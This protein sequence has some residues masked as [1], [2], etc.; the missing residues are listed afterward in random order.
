MQAPLNSKYDD[1][2]NYVHHISQPL[3]SGAQ[4]VA[5]GVLPNLNMIGVI[6]LWRRRWRRWERG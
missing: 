1:H 5:Q 6:F 4:L 3:F 2:H